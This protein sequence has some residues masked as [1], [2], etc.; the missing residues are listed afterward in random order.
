MKENGLILSPS[1]LSHTHFSLYF[2]LWLTFVHTLTYHS[3]L[4]LTISFEISEH[5]AFFSSFWTDLRAE[6]QNDKVLQNHIEN[7]QNILWWIDC[8]SAPIHMNLLIF[9]WGAELLSGSPLVSTWLKECNLLHREHNPY[10]KNRS[11]YCHETFHDNLK[12]VVM[13]QQPW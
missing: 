9:F 3:P 10:L 6:V 11:I 7:W 13:C 8:L 4:N 2:L 12:S 1:P 5:I